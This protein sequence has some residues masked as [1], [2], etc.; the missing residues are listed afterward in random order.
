MQARHIGT[1][2]SLTYFRGKQSVGD[3]PIHPIETKGDP[4]IVRVPIIQ[5]WC[6][7]MLSTVAFD[8]KCLPLETAAF[9]RFGVDVTAAMAL[10][11]SSSG[12]AAERSG[13]DDRVMTVAGL[14]L[15]EF[16]RADAEGR[17]TGNG[18]GTPQPYCRKRTTVADASY[19]LSK[20]RAV[21]RDDER[22][23]VEDYEA[24]CG[25]LDCWEIEDLVPGPPPSSI[26]PQNQSAKPHI[27]SQ[28]STGK[29][30]CTEPN[31]GT[32]GSVP[33]VGPALR[34]QHAAISQTVHS[35]NGVVAAVNAA[36]E[37]VQK[38][39]AATPKARTGV[40]QPPDVSPAKPFT[41]AQLSLIELN[42]QKA[43]AAK[44]KIK[45]N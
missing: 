27:L 8:R 5:Q 18:T 36:D 19:R 14:P 28:V 1:A 32:A 29:S 7:L 10:N 2:L 6:G 43:L 40:R 16:R 34:S 24:I 30:E 44:Q 42:K 26:P 38:E 4:S 45:H 17:P 35:R 22:K 25:M 15:V 21:V 3:K 9:I 23:H 41:K 39:L 12:T 33:E 11:E 31:S 13:A 20:I 37:G